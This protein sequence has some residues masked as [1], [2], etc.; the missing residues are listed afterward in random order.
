[1]SGSVR[2]M[3]DI[4]TDIRVNGQPVSL[5]DISFLGT[6]AGHLVGFGGLPDPEALSDLTDRPPPY[7]V[8]FTHTVEGFSSDEVRV[9]ARNG[10]SDRPGFALRRVGYTDPEE[11]EPASG[12]VSERLVASPAYDLPEMVEFFDGQSGWEF[13]RK[14]EVDHCGRGKGIVDC[15]ETCGAQPGEG[16]FRLR[17]PT[18]F[19]PEKDLNGAIPGPGLFLGDDVSEPV[20]ARYDNGRTTG[21]RKLFAADLLVEGREGDVPD[22]EEW[23]RGAA[24]VADGD[25]GALTV[26]N[27]FDQADL[28]D[29]A[30]L[31]LEV[32]AVD[33]QDNP[34][35]G[36]AAG[37]WTADTMSADVEVALAPDGAGSAAFVLT[38]SSA[39]YGLLAK[40]RVRV[41][42]LRVNVL[43]DSL[44]QCGFGAPVDT[45]EVEEVE[46][47]S[48]EPGKVILVNDGDGDADGIPDY[49]DGYDL[50]AESSDDDTSSG[51]SFVPVV[52]E[53]PE[54]IDVAEAVVNLS[55]P[56]SD[57]GAVATNDL[58]VYVLPSGHL[59]LWARDGSAQRSTNPVWSVSAPGD[60]LPPTP[61][62]GIPATDLGFSDSQR[63]RTFYAEAVRPSE[64]QGDRRVAFEVDPDGDGPLGTVCTDAARVTALRVRLMADVNMDGTIDDADILSKDGAES[65]S[66]LV[67]VNNATNVITGALRV[68]RSDDIVNETDEKGVDIKRMRLVLTPAMSEGEL[69]LSLDDSE[70]VRV[71]D[72]SDSA[73]LGPEGGTE[74]TISASS[75]PT[76]G[77]EYFVEA[78][79]GGH[80]VRFELAYRPGGQFEVGPDSLQVSTIGIAGSDGIR[81]GSLHVLPGM[82]VLDVDG[83]STGQWLSFT[84]EIG[85]DNPAYP[86]ACFKDIEFDR[87][88]LSEDAMRRIGRGEL[89]MF[90]SSGNA[91]VNVA[92]ALWESEELTELLD[93]LT[94]LWE[95]EYDDWFEYFIGQ[96]YTPEEA[97]VMTIDEIGY[98]PTREWVWDTELTLAGIAPGDEQYYWQFPKVTAVGDYLY[99]LKTGPSI[100]AET[101]AGTVSILLRG[102]TFTPDP[103]THVRNDAV[104]IL[105]SDQEYVKASLTGFSDGDEITY[106]IQ[107]PT[108][109]KFRVSHGD[110]SVELVDSVV[111]ERPIEDLLIVGVRPGETKLC[112][113]VGDNDVRVVA[114]IPISVGGKIEVSYTEA[115]T[116]SG[117]DAGLGETSSI[118]SELG[119]AAV[120]SGDGD[121]RVG[122]PESILQ[123]TSSIPL[124][125]S[126]VQVQVTD[127]LGRPKP[128]KHVAAVA[129]DGKLSTEYDGSDLELHRYS[130]T[131]ETQGIAVLR[132]SA[133]GNVPFASG[134]DHSD[135]E[136]LVGALADTAGGCNKEVRTHSNNLRCLLYT[137]EIDDFASITFRMPLIN[138]H[139]YLVVMQALTGNK[140]ASETDIVASLAYT[141]YDDFGQLIQVSDDIPPT[142][143]IF[144]N[145]SLVQSEIAPHVVSHP[146]FENAEDKPTFLD[147]PV[148]EASAIAAELALSM[149]PGYDFVDCA[150]EFFW[151]P[152][153]RSESPNY[154]TGLVSFLGLCA[155]AGYLSGV[156]GVV[157]NALVGG[158][159]AVV[160]FINKIPGGEYVLKKVIS[161]FG[162]ILNG[163]KKLGELLARVPDG[164]LVEKIRRFIGQWDRMLKSPL[165]PLGDNVADAVDVLRKA[166]RH[167]ADEAA[168]G[169]AFCAKAGKKGVAE[170]I[171]AAYGDDL[172]EASFDVIRKCDL[173]SGLI[174][175]NAI[176]GVATSIEAVG[177][178]NK[179]IVEGIMEGTAI[180]AS[181]TRCSKAFENIHSVRGV[182]GL[183]DYVTFLKNNASN[184]PGVDGCIFEGTVA[185][186]I[187]SGAL[188][189]IEGQA[190]GSLVRVS[191]DSIP[192][193]MKVDTVTGNF[194]LQ[195]KH[196]TTVPP[197][198]GIGE[199]GGGDDALAYLDALKDQAL[200]MGKT[201]ALITNCPITAPL[202]NELTLRGIKWAQIAP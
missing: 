51:V 68:N 7:V 182:D 139:Q 148:V 24:L 132:V 109:A 86:M 117:S 113:T 80:E 67:G 193:A 200:A 195:V 164:G 168:E 90:D 58:G 87:L 11:G 137:R 29:D 44:N 18:V 79:E 43:V 49:A 23:W 106:R 111:A 170:E 202:A 32:Q 190:V 1:M 55:Y 61:G 126:Q 99:E 71:F 72:D 176:K 85:T 114:D 118:D 16:L 129:S 134:V 64:T 2:S 179:A 8:T 121:A 91:A 34:F 101:R 100:S 183:D 128:G 104:T 133:S 52:F 88:L 144:N 77:I 28:P 158:I 4:V 160:K 57:P 20:E 26:K 123:K 22:T 9:E 46:D 37:P 103:D 155:D 50:L 10:I 115:P 196:K 187:K 15:V 149:A 93:I 81:I 63:S 166:G 140:Y 12:T 150:K 112:A 108:L 73:V 184:A 35:A 169:V 40:D 56:A 94:V 162:K 89:K 5:S 159:K 171:I 13:L 189:E 163:V 174:S 97:H 127:A 192:G 74:H 14:A 194:A 19:V 157:A 131:D 6:P 47:D 60:Y 110:G 199:L 141:T 191:G 122:I 116:F 175:E 161:S 27:P 186:S 151:R 178:G 41:G 153:F 119:G 36:F 107:D 42:V 70:N 95:W 83:K 84:E 120:G 92:D 78:L 96:L 21:I 124:V 31:T 76:G 136:V 3:V 69:A 145:Q 185:G 33:G 66:F 146:R 75:V 38:L 53:I 45:D 177:T 188:V 173:P 82:P 147:H 167:Y 154:I 17:L 125:V 152:F 198:F 156:G 142:E 25:P 138:H 39:K 105:P 65:S 130:T 30:R 59:R 102:V 54:P 62:G 98:A 48:D 172:A 135:L 180:K 197:N 143:Y 201:P 181:S 165:K